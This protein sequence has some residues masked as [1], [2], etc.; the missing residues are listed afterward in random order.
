MVNYKYRLFIT[1]ENKMKKEIMLLKVIGFMGLAVFGGSIFLYCVVLC[2]SVGVFY[3]MAG[4]S[5][6]EYPLK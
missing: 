1:R 4:A 5:V 3:D 6:E 2:L